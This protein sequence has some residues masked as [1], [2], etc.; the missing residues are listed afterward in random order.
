MFGDYDNKNKSILIVGANIRHAEALTLQLVSMGHFVQ[1]ALN[2]EQALPLL[3]NIQFD[4]VIITVLT[5]NENGSVSALQYL[6][7]EGKRNHN[8]AV[9]AIS[10]QSD[11]EN[12]LLNKRYSNIVDI[13]P[14][15]TKVLEICQI[16]SN[17]PTRQVLV[18][19][20]DPEFCLLLKRELEAGGY[21]MVEAL[22]VESAIKLLCQRRFLCAILDV[23]M[24]PNQT[25]E[26]VVRHLR[27]LLVDDINFA[28][29]VLVT[30]AYVNDKNSITIMNKGPMVLG[31][32]KKPFAKGEF[33]K[34]LNHIYTFYASGWVNMLH[35][36]GE[37]VVEKGGLAAD[38]QLDAIHNLLVKI[39]SDGKGDYLGQAEKFLC[40][41]SAVS[42]AVDNLDEDVSLS[43]A[44]DDDDLPERSKRDNKNRESDASNNLPERSNGGNKVSEGEASSGLSSEEKLRISA[45]KEAAV[46]DPQINDTTINDIIERKPNTR[47]PSGLTPLMIYC[48]QG[49]IEIAKKLIMKGA[50]VAL[51]SRSGQ[52]SLHYAARAGN[53]ELVE[54]LLE[55]GVKINRLD[56]GKQG[57]LY[58]AVLSRDLETV[59]LI[60]SKGGKVDTVARGKTLLMLALEMN[61][62][63]IMKALLDGGADTTLTDKIGRTVEQIARVTGN[64]EALNILQKKTIK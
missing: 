44:G 24:G 59:C 7:G 25:T 40:Q 5:S 19:D 1:S 61:E 48:S 26:P 17:L 38:K 11:Y 47:G 36:V 51:A 15:A 39:A 9:L 35:P 12:Q 3:Q 6:K 8:L 31:V 37:E 33:V 54:Y 30:S 22:N 23:V 56:R 16:V 46:Y 28:L 20:D 18:V 57:T 63:P 60:L 13:V 42:N 10:D 43:A 32:I 34:A 49:N 52:T 2:A 4:C 55:R 29:P 53:S 41:L 64:N 50:N 14:S 58:K 21:S 62:M 27:K 45:K